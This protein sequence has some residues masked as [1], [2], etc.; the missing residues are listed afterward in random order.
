MTDIRRFTDT[1]QPCSQHAACGIFTLLPRT[2]TQLDS[3]H[4]ND[5]ISTPVAGAI[6]I[7][8]IVVLGIFVY[9]WLLAQRYGRLIVALMTLL[10]GAVFVVFQ[11][12]NS[13]GG[14]IALAA[15]WAFGPVLAGVIVWRMQSKTEK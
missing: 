6:T 11:G 4:M 9:P 10:L 12:G 15:A 8:L 2:P 7:A 3:Q 1:P 13:S 5:G 14:S